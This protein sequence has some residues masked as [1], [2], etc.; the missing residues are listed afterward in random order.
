MYQN[1]M[2]HVAGFVIGTA[3][4]SVLDRVPRS[5]YTQLL[6]WF[7][8]VILTGS[9]LVVTLSWSCLMKWYWGKSG[10]ILFTDQFDLHHPLLVLGLGLFS[11]CVC[12]MT[13]YWE[14]RDTSETTWPIHWVVFR[15]VTIMIP[16]FIFSNGI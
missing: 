3:G 1:P 5:Q 8:S 7:V 11:L 16:A 14:G 10:Q 12:V 15:A 2:L 13:F 6:R 9:L 4:F